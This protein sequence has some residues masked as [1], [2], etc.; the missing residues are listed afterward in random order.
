MLQRDRLAA[1]LTLSIHPF[2]P[3]PFNYHLPHSVPSI[4]PSLHPRSRHRDAGT[5]G[6]LY[7]AAKTLPCGLLVFEYFIPL[8]FVFGALNEVLTLVSSHC[9]PKISCWRNKASLSCTCSPSVLY[10]PALGVIALR[11][12]KTKQQRRVHAHVLRLPSRMNLL[13]SAL[14]APTV[15]N[16]AAPDFKPQS[17]RLN[18]QTE[19]RKL[20]RP[21]R[22]AVCVCVSTR[23]KIFMTTRVIRSRESR[24]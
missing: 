24:P 5:V 18:G 2:P 1:A 11:N 9:S 8:A 4:H 20:D 6:V 12:G 17:R 10:T 16:W 13:T 19:I 3:L 15:T 14:T 21:L 22:F 7:S 23:A